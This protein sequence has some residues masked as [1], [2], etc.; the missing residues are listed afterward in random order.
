V[1]SP[2]R[3]TT[4]WRANS[5]T[6]TAGPTILPW[7][8][9]HANDSRPLGDSDSLSSPREESSRWLECGLLET[10]IWLLGSS[11]ARHVRA[12]HSSALPWFPWAS[13]T[14]HRCLGS[15][16]VLF[17]LLQFSFDYSPTLCSI[18]VASG[19]HF[20]FQ[21]TPDSAKRGTEPMTQCRSPRCS[22]AAATLGCRAPVLAHE[23]PSY[24]QLPQSLAWCHG[25]GSDVHRCAHRHLPAAS[26]Q[27][28]SRPCPLITFHI[29][30]K[31][32]SADIAPSGATVMI[33]RFWLH[34][35]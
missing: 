4:I 7:A 25:S 18:P 2:A 32:I 14:A 15:S 16:P 31:D 11:L 21:K 17:P 27:S 1:P 29:A 8:E 24:L 28:L 5:G 35:C 3:V 10:A 6:T 22:H 34:H 23:D 30:H 20:C 26:D 19:R 13:S 9:G 33:K 12:P